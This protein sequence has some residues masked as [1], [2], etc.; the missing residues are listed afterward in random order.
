MATR[1]SDVEVDSEAF[2]RA[3][4]TARTPLD[5]QDRRAMIDRIGR[6]SDNIIGVGPI[7]IGLDGILAWI[8]GLGQVY[9]L[10][11]GGFLIFEGYRARVSPVVLVQV[12][13]IILLR[14][15]I[16][17][18]NFIPFVDIFTS[19]I[20]DLFRGHKW[21][22]RLLTKAIDETLYLEG[23]PNPTSPAYLDALARIRRGGDKRRIVF[24]G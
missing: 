13:A 17:S 6:L 16:D 3:G 24:L 21:A 10:G 5:I 15:A 20:V 14:T 22:A 12:A 9:S 4:F 23:P 18:G 8:P 7:G 19:L 11:A 1:F 2:A